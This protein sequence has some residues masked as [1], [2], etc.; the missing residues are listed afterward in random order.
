MNRA[1]CG[2]MCGSVGAM[3]RKWTYERCLEIA[4][5]C[6][7]KAEFEERNSSAY[8]ASRE[9]GWLSKFEWLQKSSSCCE[10]FMEMTREE[11]ENTVR[12]ICEDFV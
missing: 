12:K 5:E 2:R 1:K 7:S 4:K 3:R 8:V 6:G 11:Y 10:A 9:K